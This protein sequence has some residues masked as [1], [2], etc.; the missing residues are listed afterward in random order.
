[1]K[2]IIIQL[3]LLFLLMVESTWTFFEV[4]EDDDKVKDVVNI[5]I[6]TNQTGYPADEKISKE[7]TRI[8]KGCSVSQ[9]SGGEYKNGFFTIILTQLS[10]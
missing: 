6:E 9:T 10:K 2:I 4:C 1:M 5:I 8:Y 7:K 3:F